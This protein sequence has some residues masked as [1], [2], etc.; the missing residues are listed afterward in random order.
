M[1]LKFKNSTAKWWYIFSS[2]SVVFIFIFIFLTPSFAITNQQI[3]QG[4]LTSQNNLLGSGSGP[5]TPQDTNQPGGFGFQ[6]TAYNATTGQSFTVQAQG[7]QQFASKQAMAQ[8]QSAA[9][10]YDQS[11]GCT[12]SQCVMT[13][14]GAQNYQ[15]RSQN[16][17]PPSYKNPTYQ[18]P[19]YQPNGGM[20]NL[21]N[22]DSPNSTNTLSTQTPTASTP[23]KPIYYQPNQNNQNTSSTQPVGS[24]NTTVEA[25]KITPPKNTKNTN[26]NNNTNP[27]P[28]REVMQGG[29]Y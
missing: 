1:K 5:S 3:F 27:N 15:N 11:Q 7:N 10:S 12:V 24:G 28:Y 26:N 22:Q 9:K 29:S 8:C 17:T 23:P 20:I 4:G 14:Q 19:Q 2:F 16:Y 6:C 21:S 25:Q 13:T 18:T